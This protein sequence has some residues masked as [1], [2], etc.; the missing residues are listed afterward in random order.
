MFFL[1]NL[2]KI[3]RLN[4]IT[5]SNLKYIEKK[6]KTFSKDLIKAKNNHRHSF[7][8]LK[9]LSGLGIHDEQ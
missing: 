7:F 4:Y 5:L 1:D 9:L 2:I 8:N 3:L 6:E